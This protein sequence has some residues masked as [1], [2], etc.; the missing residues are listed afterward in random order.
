MRLGTPYYPEHWPEERWTTDARLMA[1]AG[2]TCIR[3]GEFAWSRMEPSEGCFDFAWLRRAIDL[4]AQYG[5]DTILCTPTPT[6]PAWLHRKYPDIHQVKSDGTVKEFGQR[7][8]ACKT[9]P[10]Y[11]LHARR[12]AREMLGALGD[13]P[14]VVA[15]QTDNEFGCHATVR[16][17][18]PNCEHAF[19]QW[20]CRHFDG[21]I[22]ALNQA[23]GTFFWGQDYQDFAEVSLPRDTPDRNGNDGQ[24]PS[25]VLN[26]Y[27]FSSDVQVEFQREQVELIRRLSPGRT[28]THNLMGLFPQIDYFRLAEDLDVVSWDNYPFGW[29]GTNRPPPPLPH[30]LM[31]GL[32]RRPVWVME[33]ASGPGGW[34]TFAPTPQPGQMRLWA[35]QAVARGADMVSFFRWRTCRF[36]REQYWH[37]ILYH[38]GIPQR[39]YD[40]LSVLGEEARRLAPE[41]EGSNVGNRV[42]VL[43]DYDSLWALEIQPNAGKDFGYADLAARWDSALA[44]LGQ[45]ADVVSPTA[46]LAGYSLVIAP[47]LHVCTDQVAARLSAYVRDGGH[48]VLG[49]RSGVKTSE[50]AVVNE[51]LPG[52]LRGLAGCHVEE[53]DAFSGIEGLELR[54]ADAS[55]NTYAACGLAEVLVPDEASE[56]LMTYRNHYY[57]GRAAAVRFATGRG[58]CTVLGT[59]LTREDT[60]RF[61]DAQ[62][63]ELGLAP[64][65]RL[66]DTVEVCTRARGDA[67]FTFYLN[68]ASEAASLPVEAAGL[69]LLTG[70]AVSQAVELPPFGVAVVKRPL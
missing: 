41:L 48:L 45:G 36:G 40:E 61:L 32:K 17:Y 51:L 14:K 31:R 63:E 4:F 2:L 58:D 35:Y 55:E 34:G 10:G 69:E 64:V 6:C 38:H 50:N 29:N 11:R 30:D 66:P 19:Q 57:A 25:L 65:T 54:L 20:L 67:S 16:C 15:W 12:I 56:I 59:V 3:M 60:L 52:L 44:R 46:D 33:Q 8:D 9:H 62:A 26:F 13:H 23:W 27:R 7:Q 53:Y 24:N 21:D 68:H 43:Y 22:G 47:S 5:L 42:A 39:R 18:C 28:I 1:E 49:P 37:G 70:V